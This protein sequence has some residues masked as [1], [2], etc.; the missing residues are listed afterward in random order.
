MLGAL[1]PSNRDAIRGVLGIDDDPSDT[2]GFD[3]S[4][5]ANQRKVEQIRA[6]IRA[7][8]AERNVD[9]W[10]RR[11]E[12]VGAPVASRKDKAPSRNHVR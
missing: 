7:I 10:T 6:R 2:P 1:T 5:P 8:L 11:F 12:A 9:E 4:D 3:G